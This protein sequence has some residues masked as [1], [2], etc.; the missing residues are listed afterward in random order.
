MS[1]DADSC[2]LCGDEAQTTDKHGVALCAA[3][4]QD[5]RV[6]GSEEPEPDDGSPHENPHDQSDVTDDWRADQLERFVE[7][8]EPYCDELRLM[9]LDDE[10]K[11]PAIQGSVR[12]DSQ[13]ADEILRTP[14]E[15]VEEIRTEGARG[16]AIYYGKPAHGTSNLVATDHDD[17]EAFPPETT[18]E[19]VTV[20]SGSG[21]GYH[22]TYIND[23]TVENA[24]FKGDVDDAGEVRADNWYCVTPGSIHPT[25]GVYHLTDENDLATLSEDDL[26]EEL[27]PTDYEYDESSPVP[28]EPPEEDDDS[29]FTN[30]I[31]MTLEEVCE[32]SPTLDDLLSSLDPPGYGHRD[33][34]RFD[35]M[36]ASRLWF[37]RFSEGDI[38][39]IIRRHR[40]REKVVE[41][42]DYLQQT[43]QKA[44]TG[45]RIETNEEETK[46]T[47]TL[48]LDT[49]DAL[50]H[51]ERV[52]FAQRRGVEWPSVEEVRDRLYDTIT[53]NIGRE[54]RA[55][56]RA[57]TGSGKTYTV[58]T[59]PWKEMDGVT[60]DQP[61]IH[62]HKT[63]PAR[64]QAAQQSAD[65]HGDYHVARSRKETC[66]VA[67]GD[68][69][70][71][72]EHGNPGLTA[73]DQPISRWIDYQCD[74]LDY[75]YS[76]VH[77]WAAGHVDGDLP[78]EMGDKECESK[79]IL[80][81]VPR[82]D[83]GATSH[84]VVHCTH[85][86]LHVPGLR[87]RTN[88]VF[89]E[90]PD[91]GMDVPPELIRQSINAYLEWA[92]TPFD[93][94]TEL[95]LGA[96]HG[97]VPTGQYTLDTDG[98]EATDSEIMRSYD[99][100]DV[101]A[102]LARSLPRHHVLPAIDDQ[103]LVNYATDG[104]HDAQEFDAEELMEL[105]E[106]L[107]DYHL[108]NCID[109][110]R[111]IV[112]SLDQDP[113]LSWH[114]ENTDVH[115][116][117]PAFARAMWASEEA[118]SGKRRG[119][120]PF[121]PPR[122]DDDADD[123]EG[124]NREYITVLFDKQFEV[125]R[126]RSV[127]D[128]MLARSVT[129]LDAHV[130]EE[131]PLWRLNIGHNTERVRVL[132]ETQ[133]TL[134]RRY[135][136][137]LFTVQVGD[138][139]NP[140]T[141][142]KW[143]DGGQGEKFRTV[144]EHLRDH[145]GEAFSTAIT[146]N[147][148]EEFIEE[149]LQDAGADDPDLMHYGAEESRND[150]AGEEV[151]YVC[152]SIDPGDEAI[153]NVVAELGLEASPVTDECSHCD[154]TGECDCDRCDD[155]GCDVCNGTGQLREHGRTFEGRDAYTADR[156]LRAIREHHVAQ[157]AGRYARDANDPDD[158]AVVYVHTDAA[159]EGFIDAYAPGVTWTT[160]DAQR[161]VLTTLRDAEGGVTAR[162]IAQETD[163][164]KRSALRTLSRAREE[165]LADAAPGAGAYGATLYE[166]LEWVSADGVADIEVPDEENATDDVCENYT[167][168]VAVQA[169]ATADAKAGS[170]DAGL[171]GYQT[172]LAV[173]KPTTDPPP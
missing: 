137:G 40:R 129:G 16:Y 60:G 90:K 12:L 92:E 111:L 86:F 138:A 128:M 120:I 68:Y 8:V 57:P 54:E 165:G 132:S 168:S 134:Y 52:R 35:M 10:G 20:M 46:A 53:T 69:D 124:W 126:A 170:W 50:D 100:D 166:P 150:F 70:P 26:P 6:G 49:V 31:D 94:Y 167:W 24:K 78:C 33:T 14:E 107:G 163:V 27:Q 67:R 58:A 98:E 102:E 76:V 136:R 131:D 75:P 15:A 109:A 169:D 121:S 71:G 36:A 2:A 125:I 108:S 153:T 144:V 3:H 95:A 38:A 30:E 154:G 51:H 110:D 9:P 141:R 160:T 123:S 155:Q 172:S 83:D 18:P 11:A 91:F 23:G 28:L 152:G 82:D 25:G 42:D 7:T 39:R 171:D 118:A 84:N 112:E 145:Y 21:R 151:G 114:R 63:R 66:P 173:V 74:V 161:A 103:T 80:D 59:T 73:E 65:T 113:P 162:E 19:T 62:A 158:N 72:N 105:V 139:T 116:Y 140:V 81:G 149:T 29:G 41:R 142:G 93:N 64:D 13:L 130:Q 47:S 148:A 97:A 1:Q 119:T 32:H 127:P 106:E 56:V 157:S 115:A 45:E 117:A 55:V 122:Y 88:I 22:Q 135:E 159:P 5:T 4:Y 101:L 99:D 96:E 17:V 37:W 146:S 48:P 143:L 147:S 43:I 87:L 77:N 156:V 104:D 89:D 133:E 44:A 164:S 79:S 85:Q 61:V 34:S